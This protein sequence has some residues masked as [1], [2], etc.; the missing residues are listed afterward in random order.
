MFYMNSGACSLKNRNA[1]MD[2]PTLYHSID[3]GLDHV[4]DEIKQ[5]ETGKSL[6]LIFV[7]FFSLYFPSCC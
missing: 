5:K 6:K 4:Y 7:A 1:D 3:D 2:N